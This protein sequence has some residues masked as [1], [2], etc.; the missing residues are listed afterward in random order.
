MDR[1]KSDT[2]TTELLKLC[3][4]EL[5]YDVFQNKSFLITGAT[6]LIGTY[7]TDFFMM[8][9]SEKR[10]FMTV[11]VLC[12]NEEKTREHFQGY[13]QDESF[14]IV[15]GDLTKNLELK[16]LYDYII[17]GAGN[18]HPK[19][20]AME[21]VETMKTAL[22]GTINLLEAL[23]VQGKET[24]APQFLLLST[25]E[26]Y[27]EVEKIG[28][29]GCKET[30]MGVIDS[31]NARSCYPESKKA[32]ET[33]CVS[34]GKEYSMDIKIA[35]LSYIYGATF[36]EKSTKA[37]VQ[38]LKKASVG[39]NIVMKS[40]GTQLRS[41]CYLA[42]AIRGIL[43]IM[44]RGICGEAY[45][46]SNRKMNV[47]I[48]EFAETLAE[49]AGVDIVFEHSEDVEKRGYSRLGKEILDS[50]KLEKLGFEPKTEL[51]NAFETI[52]KI[53]REWKEAR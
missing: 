2:Y 34:Y 33:L 26:V 40:P 30:D 46:I 18:N 6:G 39:E 9:K 45:N 32:A 35:R 31:M 17:H 47:T 28:L 16:N 21:P 20:F 51:K 23:R 4:E 42:D 12:R 53:Q 43:I 48:R 24:T 19:V 11:S 49:A 10:I 5:P 15:C 37:D 22:I 52:L 13:L 27:G 25:G 29:A 1:L 8:L 44:L 38:F 36:Q 14:H 3:N 50:E 7:L 41:Y